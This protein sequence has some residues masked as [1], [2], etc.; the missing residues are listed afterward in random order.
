MRLRRCCRTAYRAVVAVVV[1]VVAAA[2]VR[3]PAG[4]VRLTSTAMACRMR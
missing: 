1:V 2:A 3:G 4:P